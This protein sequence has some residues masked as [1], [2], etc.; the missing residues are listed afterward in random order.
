MSRAVIQDGLTNTMA[1]VEAVGRGEAF[2]ARTYDDPNPSTGVG[3]IPAA[4]KKR[5]S[6]R[7]AEPA[8]ASPVSGPPGATN[9]YNGKVVNNNAQPVGGPAGCTW[10]T[11]DCGPNGEPFSFHGNGCNCLFAD[12][13]VNYIRDDIDAI[14]LRRM[15]TASEGVSYNYQQ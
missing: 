10:T 15:I 8:T 11:G 3:F 9:P 12:G 2:A 14:T 5:E 1:V 7:W 6:W 4:S 13:H